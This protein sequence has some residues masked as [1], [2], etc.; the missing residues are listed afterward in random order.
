MTINN[1][2]QQDKIN[3]VKKQ[4]QTINRTTQNWLKV[5]DKEIVDE[6][7]PRMNP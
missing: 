1:T 4:M 7:F 2:N 5:E 6:E 3:L